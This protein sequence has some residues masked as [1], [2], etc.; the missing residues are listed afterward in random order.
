M[1]KRA[2]LPIILIVG[3]FAIFAIYYLATIFDKPLLSQGKETIRDEEVLKKVAEI[4]SNVKIGLSE[5]KI[6]DLF[7]D[8]YVQVEHHGDLDETGFDQY[9]KYRFYQDENY[10]P[11]VPDHVMDEDGL[12]N[13]MIGFELL[14]GWKDKR[15]SLY[16]IAYTKAPYQDLYFYLNDEG[17]TREE[18]LKPDGTVQIMKQGKSD[19]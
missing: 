17:M 18:V 1:H 15:V 12:R 4:Q 10:R 7:G 6:R 3:S 8:D 19:Q 16:S 5:E 14:I 9:W 2:R 11:S 13:G